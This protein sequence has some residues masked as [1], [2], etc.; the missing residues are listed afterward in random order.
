MNNLLNEVLAMIFSV[1]D[2]R[3]FVELGGPV[4]LMVI[5][6]GFFMWL[7]II[8]RVFY[9]MFG[10]PKDTALFREKWMQRTEHYSWQAKQIRH[11][12]IAELNLRV[13]R[14]LH[15][16]KTLIALA[17]MLGLLGTVTGMLEV[18][19]VMAL[20]GSS[21]ARAMAAGIS[22]ATIPTMAGMVTALSGIYIN[23]LLTGWAKRSVNKVRYQVLILKGKPI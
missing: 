14:S 9:L 22:K 15:L 16:I 20:A 5:L 4:L 18:F 3:S 2:L 21:N 8:E 19:D 23:A 6:A 7:L 11:G 17:P 12:M 1:G 10:L 13:S